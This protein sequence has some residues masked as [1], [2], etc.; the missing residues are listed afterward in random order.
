MDCNKSTTQYQATS[1]IVDGGYE[2]KRYYKCPKCGT[3]YVEVLETVAPNEVSDKVV[4]VLK[5]TEKKKECTLDD[6]F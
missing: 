4:D 5:Y 2:T 6:W 3:V 1:L